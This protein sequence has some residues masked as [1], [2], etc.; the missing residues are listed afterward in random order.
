[1]QLRKTRISILIAAASCLASAQT[2][3]VMVPG[4]ARNVSA[5]TAAETTRTTAK[6]PAQFVAVAMMASSTGPSMG[7]AVILIDPDPGGGGGGTGGGG[8]GGG[9]T[10][11]TGGT[12]TTTPTYTFPADSIMAQILASAPADTT[13]NYPY[14]GAAAE[15]WKGSATLYDPSLDTLAGD[16]AAL[17]GTGTGT[18]TTTTPT[19]AGCAC[20]GAEVHPEEIV[21]P[22][23]ISR[24]EVAYIAY[25]VWHIDHYS[26]NFWHSYRHSNNTSVSIL[27]GD[28]NGAP[29]PVGTS[30]VP[31]IYDPTVGCVVPF[32]TQCP[33]TEGPDM[34]A[35]FTM[36]MLCPQ[37]GR[38]DDS[39]GEYIVGTFKVKVTLKVTSSVD[40]RRWAVICANGHDQSLPCD[41]NG[42]PVVTPPPPP[43]PPPGGG[44]SGGGVIV[45]V[46]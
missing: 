35:S 17:A 5:V 42:L 19:Q 34:P 25:Q 9:G 14:T 13:A 27:L 11:G 31:T 40:V 28:I 23:A 46:L 33:L 2:A 30:A 20:C 16:M 7:A 10:G 15:P 6:L 45:I 39:W 44:G 29:L 3:G 1:M 24:D 41:G 18:T 8:T 4:P 21:S 22:Q 26:G 32:G 38:H 12:G 43:P 37:C 36:P